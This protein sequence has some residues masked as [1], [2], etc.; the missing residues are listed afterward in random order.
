MGK[1]RRK[2]LNQKRLSNY[3][4]LTLVFLSGLLTQAQTAS[5]Y[6]FTQSN[7]TYTS[8]NSPHILAS[9]A[10]DGEYH[11]LNE[12]HL[13]D[14]YFYFGNKKYTKFSMAENG[15]IGMGETAI[16]GNSYNPIASSSGPQAIVS[17]AGMDIKG[18]GSNT[19]M[20]YKL[21]GTAPNRELVFEWNNVKY[22]FSDNTSSL[23]FQIRLEESTDKIRIV[24]GNMNSDG[25][26]G[27][28]QIGIQT[29]DSG[30]A[31]YQN[32]KTST[33]WN[34]TV[35]GTSRSSKCGT[36]DILPTNGLTLLY[37]YT[38][39]F[40]PSN[41]NAITTKK[42]E[43]TITWC[44]PFT[45]NTWNIE[46]GPTGFTQGM[47]TL[48]TGQTI[49]ELIVSG[50]TEQTAYD[51]Y[52]QADC[53]NGM[54][55]NWSEVATLSTLIGAETIPYTQNFE[56]TSDEFNFTGTGTNQFTTGGATSNGGSNS[57]YVS[58]DSGTSNT[59]DKNNES[60]SWASVYLDLRGTNNP[61][62]SFDWKSNGE[63]GPT[64]GTVFDY[65][66]LYIEDEAGVDILISNSK[67]FN[68]TTSYGTKTINL[69]A[70]QGQLVYLKFKWYND[71]NSGN[72]PPFAID[73]I[74]ITDDAII[75]D[76]TSWS[77]TNGPDATLNATIAGDYT[78][79]T[80]LSAFNL[81]IDNGFT[82]TIND[83]DNLTITNSS[84]NNG[85]IVIEN[86]ANLLQTNDAS[87]LGTGSY[88]IKRNSNALKRLDYTMWSSPVEGINLLAFSPNTLTDRFY[89]YNTTTNLF[90]VI[91]PSSNDFEVGEGYLIR[92]PDNHPTTPTI[93]TGIFSGSTIY[94]GRI[95]KTVNE[96][97]YNMIG[98]PYPS[99]LDA[100]TFIAENG[101]TDPIYFWRKENN[102]A[103]PSYATYTTAGGA[104]NGVANTGGDPIGLVPTNIINLA[105]GFIIKA[106]SNKITFKN[107]QRI[108][109][110][111]DMS[112]RTQNNVER[113]RI[114]LNL[115]AD[116]GAS[117]QT[118]VA[119][120][121]GATEDVDA[122]IDGKPFQT[123]STS[124]TSLVNN[125]SYVIQGRALPFD[126]NDSV[127]L[128]FTTDVNGTFTI[129]KA[130]VDGLFANGQEVFIQDNLAGT[131]SLLDSPYTFASNAGT[132]DNRFE[133]VYKTTLSNN[134]FDTAE[135]LIA[136]VNNNNELTIN[137]KNTIAEIQ[138]FDV[139]G[140][141]LL[142]QKEV[143][144]TL[145]TTPSIWNNSIGILKV[146]TTNG[147][148]IS[149]KIKL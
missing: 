34:A 71:T 131:I 119:Y 21:E 115:N 76:G 83:G 1:T 136:F 95:V 102:S 123:A 73:N 65:G 6:I 29:N 121:T 49:D 60:T 146:T 24:Y 143:N 20:S 10:F 79:T 106:T 48:I 69:S 144:N 122:A 28:A 64:S 58:K 96:N 17:A 46:Y 3:L 132:F 98:N 56:G 112:F 45:Q 26:S 36:D 105:Q 9:G 93:Y 55:S 134:S 70:F 52:V 90:N 50:L 138:L 53:G 120:M 35:I 113:N 77:N 124:L 41:I 74:S 148:T 13:S 25:T 72:N 89:N 133:I 100:D 99:G 80:D 15:F 94:N 32:R 135:S 47:G 51:F 141:L 103:N 92:K 149:K 91:D 101:I 85:T 125:E 109:D 84:I 75:W 137:T 63:V 4:Y 107:N 82:V 129:T 147:E 116:N 61:S 126:D 140:R 127:A 12:T 19:T 5:E 22:W 7:S 38:G 110:N 104:S 97:K 14:F 118:M 139:T 66:E 18:V 57:L 68:S 54:T 40:E 86:N 42:T 11:F 88:I 81:T 43:L 2:H 78:S 117:Y 30:N 67:E 114:W 44:H 130:N 8:L 87:N 108:T 128:R 33:D 16:A 111:D 23:N 59:Y 27:N 145:F 39:C 62:L 37:E 31:H 142:N